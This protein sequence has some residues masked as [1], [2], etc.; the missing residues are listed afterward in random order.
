MSVMVDRDVRTEFGRAG[1]T[2]ARG[3]QLIAGGLVTASV[4]VAGMLALGGFQPRLAVATLLIPIGLGLA[5][6][7]V[8]V[9][10]RW[11]P[12]YRL[13]IDADGIA[14]VQRRRRLL[15][16]WPEVGAWWIGVPATARGR[17]TRRAGLLVR[18]ADRVERPGAEPWRPIWLRGP[19]LWLVCEP[20]LTNGTVDEIVRALRRYAADREAPPPAAVP[21]PPPRSAG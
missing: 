6:A 15:I 8:A 14:L 9:L 21:P 1:G 19:R 2:V 11:L 4:P 18:P 20:A 13:A 17:R 7:G 16:R 10:W 5:G 3:W 12:R